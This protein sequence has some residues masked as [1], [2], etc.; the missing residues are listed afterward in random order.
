M[1]IVER[2]SESPVSTDLA[3]LFFY[4]SFLVPLLYRFILPPYLVATSMSALI[5][6]SSNYLIRSQTDF[7]HQVYLFV[8]LLL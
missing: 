8:I 6:W 4:L 1:Q 5:G 3:K 2:E 7:L